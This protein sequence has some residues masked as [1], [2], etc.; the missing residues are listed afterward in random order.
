[1]EGSLDSREPTLDLR[2]AGK[3]VIF[4]MPE[5]VAGLQFD[6]VYLIHVDAEDAPKEMSVGDRRRFISAVY[7]GASRAERELHIGCSDSRGGPA[8]VLSLAIDRGTLVPSGK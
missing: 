7:L 3:K 6:T 4:S 5:Y 1:M 8:S 2:H